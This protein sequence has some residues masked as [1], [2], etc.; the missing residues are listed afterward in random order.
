[1]EWEHQDVDVGWRLGNLPNPK[2]YELSD[3]KFAVCVIKP[4]K[5]QQFPQT[6]M[7]HLQAIASTKRII[8]FQ[9]FGPEKLMHFIST[10]Y[11]T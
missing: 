9:G 7:K 8:S 11:L 4:N 10:T 6:H 1:M 5:L 2:D 3:I